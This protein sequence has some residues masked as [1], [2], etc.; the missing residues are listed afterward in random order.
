M[1][2]KKTKKKSTLR[3]NLSDVQRDLQKSQAYSNKKMKARAKRAYNYAK[4]NPLEVTAGVILLHPAAR[5]AGAAGKAAYKGYKALKKKSKAI[6]KATDIK[7]RRGLGKK[8]GTKD[9]YKTEAQ[10]KKALEG[11]GRT[12]RVRSEVVTET[13]K[14]K[15]K[16]KVVKKKVPVK[17]KGKTQKYKRGPNKGKVKYTTKRERVTTTGKDTTQKV[18]RHKIDPGYTGKGGVIRNP[19]A[20]AGVGSAIYGASVMRRDSA[21]K[22]KPKEDVKKKPLYMMRSSGN[23]KG[24]TVSPSPRKNYSSV[25]SNYTRTRDN[26]GT[27]VTKSTPRANT[28]TQVRKKT[29]VKKN[30]TMHGS[31]IFRRR[32]GGQRRPGSRGGY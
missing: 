27:R 32:L 8:V 26:R 2:K 9:Y 12:G 24:T 14:G 17:V 22:T 4:E 20:T 13:V 16:S 10:A 5:A 25:E 23:N 1:A 19:Y 18:T 7:V 11:S 31:E 30:P 29:Q 21:V 28:R 3:R 6:T 15:V